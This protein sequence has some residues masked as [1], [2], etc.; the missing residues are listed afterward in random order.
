LLPGDTAAAYA[1][2]GPTLRRS[3]SYA[4]YQAFWAR[5]RAVRLTG[6]QMQSPTTATGELDYTLTDGSTRR[7]L[8]QFTLVRSPTGRLVLD[9]D[10]FVRS[11]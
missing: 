7:E 9:S 2:T 10:T 3:E 4:N 1:L 8:H 6:V 11:L 5:F